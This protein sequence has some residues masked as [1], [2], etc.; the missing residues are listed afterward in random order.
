MSS[1]TLS[2]RWLSFVTTLERV[3]KRTANNET[4]PGTTGLANTK[5]QQLANSLTISQINFAL[6]QWWRTMEVRHDYSS[7]VGRGLL[8]A[9]QL[10]GLAGKTKDGPQARRLLTLAAIYDGATRTEA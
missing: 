3:D 4:P 10:R 2:G 1:L 9:S 6:I 7:G 5:S 8:R